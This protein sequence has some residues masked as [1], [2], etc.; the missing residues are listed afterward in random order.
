MRIR[1]WICAGLMMS[2]TISCTTTT[3]DQNSPSSAAAPAASGNAIEYPV[4]PAT[5]QADT[6]HGVRVED[7][8]RFL[9]DA[10]DPRTVAWTEQ[11]NA[12]TARQLDKP[13][14]E[15]IKSR[16][17]ELFDYAR[18]TVPFERGGRYYFA[19]NEGLQNQS[20]YYVQDSLS[21]VPRVAIDP[22]LLSA[23]GTV[24]LTNFSP[25]KD[26]RLLGYGVSRG[27]SDRQELFVRD[28]ATGKDLA[29]KIEWAK[30]TSIDWA[31]DGKGFYYSK[32]PVPGT[33][34][35]GDEHYYPKL[36]YHRVGTPQSSDVV[37]YERPRE[38]EV[39]FGIDVTDDGRYVMLSAARGSAGENEVYLASLGDPAKLD[40]I[41]VFTGFEHLYVPEEIVGERMFLLTNE[42]AP[43]G[44]VIAVDLKNFQQKTDIV[45]ESADVLD[46]IGLIDG[47]I[48]AHYLHNASSLL[49]IFDLSGKPLGEIPLPGIGAVSGMTGGLSDR[50]M[51]F[52]FQSY[53]TAPTNFRYDFATNRLEEI[54][55]STPKFDASQ[56][57]TTQVWYPSRDGTR[58][59][60][61]LSHRKGLKPG[62]QTPVFLY[63]YGG[64]QV[65]MTPAFNP[66]HYYFIEQGG[67][68]AVANLRGGSEYGEEWHKAGMLDK[69][70]NVFDDFAAA[71][72]WLIAN[73]YTSREKL[74]VS[75]RSNGGL[76]AAVMVTQRP[77][78]FEAAVVQVPVIDM[79]RYH[80]FTVGRFWIPEYGSAEDPEQFKFLHAYSPLHNIRRGTKYP[81]TLVT[82]ADFDDRVDPG[83]AKK[84]A[85]TLQRAQGGG[86]P[87]LIR[88]ETNAGH[89]S[90]SIGASGK[91]VAKLIEEWADIWTFVF[92]QL[93]IGT[94]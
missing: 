37:V 65:S 13:V 74:A 4:T 93:N 69:K 42:N 82:T 40:F 32:Y 3:S 68:F 67:I 2:F 70:Q 38:R 6:Y 79:L 15:R 12:L 76:L 58:V 9:E 83:Q 87:I 35:A 64:F 46:S 17:R 50:E 92:D 20:I 24:A 49:K 1:P 7:P 5:A 39:S 43:R 28:L 89:S 84:F 72:E 78:L 44:K 61:F 56:F 45:P 88:V 85:A 60:M 94:E 80:T 27:G 30:F 66:V 54:A 51:F 11:Q 29:D 73:G 55:K 21:G 14:R 52:G 19:K 16:L 90:G 86:E 75:G 26:G 10:R 31:P 62:P 81:A 8:Y 77:D 41:P 63:G 33:V 36:Y 71:G 59:S 91:P 53:T 25:T 23:D 57:E 34:P 48:V 47:K 22:N 18:T